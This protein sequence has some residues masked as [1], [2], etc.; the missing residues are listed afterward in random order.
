MLRC[1]GKERV[2][3]EEEFRRRLPVWISLTD[4]FLD[5]EVTQHG[6]RR[7]AEVVHDAGYSVHEVRQILLHEVAPVFGSNLLTT[8][9][10]WEPWS[11]D[12]V[13]KKMRAWMARP[14][15]AARLTAALAWRLLRKHWEELQRHLAN[16]SG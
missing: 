1:M 9:G 2:L 16:P 6:Y 10:E 13:E 14:R 8:V 12:F 7:M 15:W 4:L 5:T 11:D 3:S